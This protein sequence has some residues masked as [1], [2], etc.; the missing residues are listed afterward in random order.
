MEVCQNI[1]VP[2]LDAGPQK[3][4][5]YQSDIY[6]SVFM[7]SRVK[8]GN[9]IVLTHLHGFLFMSGDC[10]C[11]FKSVS[12]IAFLKSTFLIALFAICSCPSIGQERREELRRP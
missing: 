3:N 5:P 2:A 1:L 10:H 6:R 7:R 4:R 8:R 11:P 12:S 9:K